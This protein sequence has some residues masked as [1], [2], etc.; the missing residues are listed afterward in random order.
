MPKTYPWALIM[1]THEQDTCVFICVSNVSG[2]K[3]ANLN[4]YILLMSP[5]VFSFSL[6][7]YLYISYTFF[8]YSFYF[9]YLSDIT[10]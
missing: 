8:K 2:Y 1:Q 10:K 4:V 9:L 6:L 3:A 7:K 5:H